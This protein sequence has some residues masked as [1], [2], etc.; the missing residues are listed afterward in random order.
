M[1]N[2]PDPK[3]PP[4]Q[5]SPTPTI[6]T[7]TAL[8]PLKAAAPSEPYLKRPQTYVNAV[9][10][11]FRQNALTVIQESLEGLEAFSTSGNEIAHVHASR[12]LE[13]RNRNTGHAL[14]TLDKVASLPF[15]PHRMIYHPQRPIS[16]FKEP[17]APK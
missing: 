14:S 5:A 12:K 15:Q 10:R 13:G 16:L 3:R 2:R 11:R 4:A 17:V 1:P 7:D 9:Q 6:Q 8:N